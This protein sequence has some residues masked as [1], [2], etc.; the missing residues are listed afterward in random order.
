MEACFKY[1]KNK[2]GKNQVSINLNNLRELIGVQEEWA[3]LSIFEDDESQQ[4]HSQQKGN[5]F[6]PQPLDDETPF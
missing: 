2:W 6:Q 4:K 3:N 1:G 5:A